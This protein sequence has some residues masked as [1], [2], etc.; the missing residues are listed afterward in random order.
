[1]SDTK[2]E[3]KIDEEIKPLKELCEKMTDIVKMEVAKGVEK[4][5]TKELSE[6]VDII[7][8]LADAKAKT[9][10]ACYHK[11]IL[12]AMESSEEEP[13]EMRGYRSQP[14]SKTSGRYMSYG[15]G[16]RS[17]YV[18]EMYDRDMPYMMGYSNSTNGM[19]TSNGNMSGN[20]AM[21][22]NDGYSKGYE[23]GMSQGRSQNAYTMSRYDRSRRGY[24]DAK[25]S[26][27]NSDSEKQMK[28]KELDKFMNEL[29]EDMK[30]LVVGMSPEEKTVWK[31][32]I[33][34]LNDMVQ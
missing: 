23:D 11:Y 34:K 30:E 5:D 32:K 25:N 26:K 20:S 33:Q 27:G 18:P 16:R 2:I 21:S 7:K 9:V 13:E 10:E 8:D 4:V 3:M 19:S 31:H 17:S 12:G 29:T 24:I 1:M 14:R 28:A 15:D 22:Y 6:A